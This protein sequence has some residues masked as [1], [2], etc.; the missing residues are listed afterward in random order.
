MAEKALMEIQKTFFNID[1]MKG[2]KLLSFA[3]LLLLLAGC[4]KDEKPID[5]VGEWRLSDIQTKVVLGSEEV[6]VYLSFTETNLF[7]L[8]QAVGP[9]R[10]RRYSGYW[11]LEGDM[12]SGTYT[13]GK[14]W[15]A[16]YRVSRDGDALI[17]SALDLSGEE[18]ERDTYVRSAIP[19]DIVA[20]AVSY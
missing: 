12:L 8:Y 11:T 4:R 10:Y 16:S 1:I 17:L 6:D 19:A 2:L 7:L 3:A 15:G 14:P 18:L 20:G 9:G 13:D 5:I